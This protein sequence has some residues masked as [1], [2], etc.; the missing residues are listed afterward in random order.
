M[1]LWLRSLL[2]K[3][4][5]SAVMLLSLLAICAGALVAVSPLQASQAKKGSNPA[6]IETNRLYYL[7]PASLPARAATFEVRSSLDYA[8]LSTRGNTVQ[9]SGGTPVKFLRQPDGLY[10]IQMQAAN[11]GGKYTYFV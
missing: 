8:L 5:V 11:N 10:K 1:Q 9:K 4:I 2:A 7:V 6:R 3:G